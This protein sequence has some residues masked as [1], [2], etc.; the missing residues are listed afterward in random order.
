MSRHDLC[1]SD[2]M[3][4]VLIKDI[5]DEIRLVSARLHYFK[6]RKCE[7]YDLLDL[8]NSTDPSDLCIKVLRKSHQI[9]E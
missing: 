9:S 2:S 8:L 6:N 4:E 1:H 3:K 5:L 7:L